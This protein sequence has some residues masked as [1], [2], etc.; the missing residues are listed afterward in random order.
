LFHQSF[1]RV[2]D[3]FTTRTFIIQMNQLE[4]LCFTGLKTEQ[5]F[6]NR[7]GGIY[8]AAKRQRENKMAASPLHAGTPGD[9]KK[10]GN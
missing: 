3:Y 1:Q 6:Y 5:M 8:Y 9:A 4:I 7:D 10:I 2:K